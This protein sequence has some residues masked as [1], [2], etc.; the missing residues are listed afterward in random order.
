MNREVFLLE[1]PG[2]TA[3]L[4]TSNSP[5]LPA[6]QDL[7]SH[8]PPTFLYSPTCGTGEPNFDAAWGFQAISRQKAQKTLRPSLSPSGTPVL[9]PV[10]ED[11]QHLCARSKSRRAGARASF[12]DL[13]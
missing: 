8:F 9:G 3:G 10:Y 13:F 1:S 2:S 4:L 7:V 11:P 12:L 6:D 5:R